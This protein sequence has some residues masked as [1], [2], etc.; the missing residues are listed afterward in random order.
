VSETFSTAAPISLYGSSK[1]CSEA[2]ALEYG[3]AFGFPVWVNRCGVLAGAGQFG[4]ADQGIFSHWIHSW[5]S[6]RPPRYIGFGG[7]G[8]QVRDCLHPNDLVG[9]ILQQLK[10]R[11]QECNRIRNLSGGINNS[12]SLRELSEWCRHRFGPSRSE[13]DLSRSDAKETRSYDIPWLV[14]DSSL[15][16]SEWNWKP[17]TPLDDVLEEIASHAENHPDWLDL[18]SR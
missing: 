1:L 9:I 11:P 17:A 16:A 4:K 12:M 15:A 14:L 10:S 13:L 5:K 18:V 8:K 6:G 3:S 7:S 2:L